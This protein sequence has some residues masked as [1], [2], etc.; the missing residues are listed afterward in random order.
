MPAKLPPTLKNVIDQFTPNI[1][2]ILWITQEQLSQNLMGFNEFNYLFDG[3]LS[4]FIYGQI[5]NQ[6]LLN[7][8]IFFTQNF[9]KTLF[10]AHIEMNIDIKN[11]VN[12]Q[13]KLIS[14][15]SDERKK[16][17]IYDTTEKIKMLELAETYPQFEFT[18]LIL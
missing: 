14:E 6:A 10:L 3:L 17:I 4:Q 9:D 1:R 7:T 16:I 5:E 12:Q 15:S 8:N 18:Q 11:N 13:L 2:G